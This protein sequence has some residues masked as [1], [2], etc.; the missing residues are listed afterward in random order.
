MQRVPE[1]SQKIRTTGGLS[2]LLYEADTPS[3]AAVDASASSQTTTSDSQPG[4]ATCDSKGALEAV[5]AGNQAAASLETTVAPSTPSLLRTDTDQ[6]KTKGSP[7]SIS[8]EP[9]SVVS[10]LPATSSTEPHSSPKI[11]LKGFSVPG[12]LVCVILCKWCYSVMACT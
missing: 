12:H 3:Q 11:N 7:V 6:D 8:F 9:P 5:D 2:L 1:A 10:P 4:T